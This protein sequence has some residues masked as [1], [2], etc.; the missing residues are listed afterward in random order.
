MNFWVDLNI[1]LASN[2][3]TKN[4]KDY[5]F[6]K[7]SGS[8]KLVP[9]VLSYPVPTERARERPWLGLVTW[10]Q[11]K[12]ISEGGV[13]CLSILCLVR[14]M[15]IRVRKSKLDFLNLQL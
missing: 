7:N 15:I 11:N 12:I 13:L 4:K 6:V 9:R 1:V 14:A 8:L 5:W 3:K 10:L 2:S